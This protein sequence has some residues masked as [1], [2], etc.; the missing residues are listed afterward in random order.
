MEEHRLRAA[1]FA[2][3]LCTL[4]VIRTAN[5]VHNDDAGRVDRLCHGFCGAMMRDMAARP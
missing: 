4:Q 2:S 1:A 5:P 3:E